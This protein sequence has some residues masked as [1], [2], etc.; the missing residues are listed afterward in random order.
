MALL[1]QLKSYTSNCHSGNMM[2]DVIINKYVLD[3]EL[4][5]TQFTYCVKSCNLKNVADINLV[6][7]LG[8]L[9]DN[10]LT[11]AE[12]SEKHL[13]SLETTIRNGYS[14]IVISNSCDTAPSTHGG[15]L[16]TAKEDKKA[17]WFWV[18]KCP[19]NTEKISRRL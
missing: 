2:L 8:N 7:I 16:V 5:N 14:M 11:A 19:Q 9:M 4:R 17:P 1:D 6:A 10:A 13:V 15:H 18:K 3:C 12:T